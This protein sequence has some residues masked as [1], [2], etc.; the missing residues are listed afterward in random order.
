MNQYKIPK[1][2]KQ[3]S[4]MKQQHK[5]K[6]ITRVSGIANRALVKK[7]EMTKHLSPSDE[8]NKLIK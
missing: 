7:K 1:A 6:A 4:T 8:E 3:G 2:T 5:K